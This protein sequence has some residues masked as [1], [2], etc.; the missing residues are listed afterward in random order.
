MYA[1]RVFVYL[2]AF[3]GAAW[4]GDFAYAAAQ[5]NHWPD[6]FTAIILVSL[7]A[8]LLFAGPPPGSNGDKH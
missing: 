6:E 3:V 1:R 4:F 2:C 5:N 7:V 8:A